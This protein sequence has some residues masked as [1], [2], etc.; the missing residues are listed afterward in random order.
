MTKQIQNIWIVVKYTYCLRAFSEIITKK[1]NKQTIK[2]I[3]TGT[4]VGP[5]FAFVFVYI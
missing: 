2:N 1:D 3:K 5:C 4:L